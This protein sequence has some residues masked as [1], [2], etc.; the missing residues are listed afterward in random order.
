MI[1]LP[2]SH[3]DDV[4]G[5]NF[6]RFIGQG[7][8]YKSCRTRRTRSRPVPRSITGVV[9]PP[10]LTLLL[11]PTR[12]GRTQEKGGNKIKYKKTFTSLSV[13]AGSLQ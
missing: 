8:L 7:F 3:P 4:M 10:P 5:I 6:I 11:R 2:E 1:T 9:P 12:T 13:F